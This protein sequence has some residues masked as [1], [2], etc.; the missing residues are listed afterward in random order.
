MDVQRLRLIG[1]V[2]NDFLPNEQGI[3][4]QEIVY[5]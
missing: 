4:V 2:F 1:G 3:Q 5:G